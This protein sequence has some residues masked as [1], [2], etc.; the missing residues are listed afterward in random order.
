M[1]IIKAT[2]RDGSPN[3]FQN[4]Q[5]SAS[6][7][8]KWQ[9]NF[10]KIQ[11]TVPIQNTEIT[12]MNFQIDY[13][14]QKVS[15]LHCVIWKQTGMFIAILLLLNG[16]Q[17]T[18]ID[19]Q[20]LD[21]ATQYQLVDWN[22][23][24]T[25]IVV[26]DIFTPP[27]CSRI[28][29][30]A[31]I[32]A[33]EVL[34]TGNDTYK[35]FAGQLKELQSIPLPKEGETL[36]LPLASG[37]AF[38]K[39]GKELVYGQDKMEEEL[40]NYLKNMG[41]LPTAVFDNSVAYGEKVAA[42]IL[43]W[44][45]KDG[46]LE[47][48]ALPQYVLQKEPGKWK[49]TPPDYMPAIEPHW[50]TLRTFVIENPEQF[51]P[52]PPTDF[53]TQ[54]HSQFYQET[55][56]VYEAVNNL[57]EE[58][59]EIAKFWDC[60]PNVSHTKGHLMFFDQ[61]ISP[62][63]HWVSIAGIAIKKQQVNLMH[64]AQILAMTT[65]TLA[66]AFISC[67][68]E[69]YRSSLVRPETYINEHIDPNWKPVLQTPPFPEY[70]SGHSVISSAAAVMLTHLMGDNVAFTDSTEVQ[71]GLPVREFTSFYAAADEAAISRLYGGIHYM[72]AIENGVTQGKIIGD[73]VVGELGKYFNK[74]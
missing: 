47:R 8:R 3:L 7:C 14:V 54:P 21:A 19:T 27:V 5:R 4:L 70:T 16:C 18:S 68:D 22:K 15:N 43:A 67:W 26:E 25:N 62:G 33:Y 12:L 60:N 10:S 1:D 38:A 45:G 31:N 49:P 23:K 50:N 58:R 41:G 9:Q 56:E 11:R 46:Y 52:I 73:Y 71:W 42:H 35:S 64:S 59:L 6:V 55:M 30:Y 63:G 29:V 69:K 17:P 37:V 20:Q 66:D 72:P 61:K 34:A 28:Y 40:Q 74:E 51:P 65:I 36:Y 13:L 57:D 24:L 53:D 48:S 39:V 2:N 32:A 44:A